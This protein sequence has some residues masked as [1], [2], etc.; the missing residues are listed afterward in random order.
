MFASH[1]WPTW[2]REDAVEF[3]SMQRDMYAYL[4]DQTL[5]LLNQGYVGSEIA[6]MLEPPPA[7]VAAWHTHGYYGSVS[8]NVKAVYQRYMGWFDGNPAHL[9]S[10]PPEAAARRYVEAMG[11]PEGTLAVAR[12][13]V[14]EGDYRWA[15]EVL[16]HL[17]FADES[18][19]AARA[20]Q[21]DAFEQLGFGAENGPWRNFFLS[22][23][24]ELRHGRFGTPAT[25]A[26]DVLDALS[27][28][29]LLDGMAIRVDGPRAW[30]ERLTVA[31]AVTDTDAVHVAE[32][33]NGVLVQKLAVA[34]P[35]GATVVTASRVDLVRL[36]TGRLDLAAALGDGTVRIDGDATVLGQ[37]LAVLAPVDPGFA[38]VT[39]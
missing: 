26:G 5:R 17:I 38:I 18:N 39:P 36:A 22:G 14:D 20:L 16:N 6:E 8:H 7:L 4:H 15:V 37:L 31:F 10:H 32:L 27:I 24:R 19:E 29:Q 33:R 12:R 21:A 11:G 28:E 35:E 34:A 3:L 2:G 25:A 9:W 13:V 23:A 1:H 30:D